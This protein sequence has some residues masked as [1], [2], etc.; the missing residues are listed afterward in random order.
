MCQILFLTVF[1]ERHIDDV[2][3]MTHDFKVWF[4]YIWTT[5]LNIQ[6][7]SLTDILILWPK[8]KFRKN[9]DSSMK[10]PYGLCILKYEDR[11]KKLFSHLILGF[12]LGYRLHFKRFWK[13]VMN[14][15]SSIDVGDEFWMQLMKT[16][17]C[18]QHDVG[19]FWDVSA[20]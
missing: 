1:V 6:T 9:V 17:T 8:I 7:Q 3:V 4:W 15:Q 2:I 5:I 13:T 14:F 11:V 19:D 16:W 10:F 20:F 12:G 18:Y